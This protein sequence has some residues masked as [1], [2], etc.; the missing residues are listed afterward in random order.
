MDIGS[1]SDRT[2]IASICQDK[3]CLWLDDIVVMNK[4]S[5]QQ[6]LDVLKQLN[7]KRH[8]RGGLID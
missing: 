1:T 3:D 8:Y 2:A 5:Y 4:A 7:E 6:Q